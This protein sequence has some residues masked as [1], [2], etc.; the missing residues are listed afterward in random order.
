MKFSIF[1]ELLSFVWFNDDV[2]WG[3][4]DRPFTGIRDSINQMVGEEIVLD[5]MEKKVKTS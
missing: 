2:K 3:R 5:W 1:K 4:I